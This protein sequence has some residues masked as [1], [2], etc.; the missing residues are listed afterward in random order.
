MKMTLYLHRYRTL[1]RLSDGPAAAE[2]EEMTD[3]L[4]ERKE[5][6]VVILASLDERGY[7]GG[8]LVQL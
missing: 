8:S 5:Q 4:A 1:E 6:L 3:E 2:I 7:L